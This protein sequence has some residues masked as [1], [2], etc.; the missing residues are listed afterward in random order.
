M[1]SINLQPDYTCVRLGKKWTVVIRDHNATMRLLYR[2]PQLNFNGNVDID[3]NIH[4]K[5]KTFP[6]IFFSHIEPYVINN[7]KA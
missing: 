6:H 1:M 2:V 3:N 5:L 7:L 4:F